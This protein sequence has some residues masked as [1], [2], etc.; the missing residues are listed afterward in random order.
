MRAAFLVPALLLAGCSGGGDFE[1]D[2]ATAKTNAAA[3]AGKAFDDAI[4]KA[5]STQA[6]SR[7]VL[8]CAAANKDLLKGAYRGVIRFADGG[9]YSVEMLPDDALSQCLE[10]AYSNESLPEPPSRPYVMPIDF[11]ASPPR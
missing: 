1:A 11:D 4:G 6:N 2:Y 3:G 10:K 9:G 5:T 7:E 8:A